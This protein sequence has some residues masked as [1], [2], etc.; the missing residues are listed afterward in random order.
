MDFN[1]NQV[2][3]NESQKHLTINTENVEKSICDVKDDNI[4]LFGRNLKMSR[5]QFVTV[6]LIFVNIFLGSAYYSLFE[7]FMPGEAIKK[8]ISQTQ[9]GIIFGVYQ[10]VMLVLSPIFGKYV[11][12]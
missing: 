1:S 9:V 2:D 6:S 7:P 8:G 3:E 10:F 11:I 5:T 12:F 4:I